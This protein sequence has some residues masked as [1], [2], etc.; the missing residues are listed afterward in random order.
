ML[1][2]N[3]SVRSLK[4]NDGFKMPF[5][6]TKLFRCGD[7]LYLRNQRKKIKNVFNSQKAT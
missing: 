6:R 7:V 3:N 4:N 1:V 2:F 5:I